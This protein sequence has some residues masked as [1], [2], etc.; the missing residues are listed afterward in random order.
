[1][2]DVGSIFLGFLFAGIVTILSRNFLDFLCLA[3]FLLP[4]YADEITTMYIR[5]S[6]NE[7]LLKPHRKHLY[8]ILVNELGI[9]H[10][11]VSIGYGIAQLLIAVIILSV[12]NIS[13]SVVV[14][15]LLLFFC[16]FIGITFS[17][18]KRILVCK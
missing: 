3:S 10:W 8:Q 13:N 2:G 17:I 18:R 9:A 6:H 4:F 5:L 15:M 14:L 7:S 1:M 11:K 16:S 12:K